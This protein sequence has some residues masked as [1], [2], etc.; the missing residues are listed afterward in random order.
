VSWERA[1]ELVE[2]ELRRVMRATA[3]SLSLPARMGGR[4]RDVSIMRELNS[5]VS[6]EDRGFVSTRETYSDA[7][8][9]V[10]AETHRR[11]CRRRS[12]GMSWQNIVKHTKIMSCSGH[13]AAEHAS[14]AAGSVNIRPDVG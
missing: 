9:T 2:R 14:S 1:L 10:A 5:S 13:P 12:G 7:A 3:M 8:G 11:E 6:R 4:A